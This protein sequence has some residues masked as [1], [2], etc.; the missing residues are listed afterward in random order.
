LSPNQLKI[1][2]RIEELGEG[3]LVREISERK[4]MPHPDTVRQN[5]PKLVAFG[6]LKPRARWQRRTL[7][8]SEKGREVLR[9]AKEAA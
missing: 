1:L 6:L 7:A 2:T 3:C 4:G 8:L 9:A 5:L